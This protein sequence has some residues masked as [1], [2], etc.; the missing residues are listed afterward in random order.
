M[1]CKSGSRFLSF[2]GLDLS[3]PRS[4]RSFSYG[5]SGMSSTLIQLSYDDAGDPE[6][7][8]DVDRVAICPSLHR[9][10]TFSAL[11]AK[12]WHLNRLFQSSIEHARITVSEKDVLRPFA[13]LL[14]CNI[15]V[16]VCWKIL[17][18]LT[19]VREEN[20]GTDY[21]NQV[22]SSYGACRSDN[23]VA[24]LLH[25]AVLNFALVAFACIQAHQARD[26]KSVFSEAKYIGLT[27][28]SLVQ[29]KLIML[30]EIFACRNQ[31]F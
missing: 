27:V 19:Y 10:F 28:T 21:W 23:A 9:V 29:A 2:R 3:L 6:T 5:R 4:N 8:G 22:I 26:V 18:P 17:D 7:I 14:T 30:Y 11:L 12:T 25:F 31:N 13:A 24:Y 20:S 15:V 16:L 1:L